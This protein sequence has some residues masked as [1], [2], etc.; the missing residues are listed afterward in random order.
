MTPDP[1]LLA[2]ACYRFPDADTGQERRMLRFDA[3][4][5]IR[6]Y[7]KVPDLMTKHN[8]RCLYCEHGP[9]CLTC[10]PPASIPDDAY[11]CGPCR[12]EITRQEIAADP[13]YQS[14]A[15][16]GDGA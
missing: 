2:L 13:Y 4:R 1:L 9:Y 14:G 11:V 8:A 6:R 10:P 5:E 15:V 12:E 3:S 16:F 7:R